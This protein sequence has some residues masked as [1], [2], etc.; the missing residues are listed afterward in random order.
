MMV[1]SSFSIAYNG[2]MYDVTAE[3]SI[4]ID[5]YMDCK[6][7]VLRDGKKILVDKLEDELYYRIEQM[8]DDNILEGNIE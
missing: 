6:Y 3:A 4:D 7:T 1:Q 5:N 2:S 8:L